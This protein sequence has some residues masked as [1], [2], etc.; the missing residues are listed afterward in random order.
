[1]IYFIQA[2]KYDIIFYAKFQCMNMHGVL[3]I[4][5]SSFDL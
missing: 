1:M 2:K 3:L 4:N 5:T